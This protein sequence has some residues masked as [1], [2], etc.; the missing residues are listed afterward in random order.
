MRRPR[1]EP[2]PDDRQATLP[3]A[4]AAARRATPT[5]EAIAKTVTDRDPSPPGQLRQARGYAA[6]RP[7][8]RRPGTT[9]RTGGSGDGEA[10]GGR[11]GDPRRRGH[12][13]AHV[14]ALER[15]T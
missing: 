11:A 1:R 4:K 8:P 15:L 5:P 7:A 6:P 14:S 10:R 9:P 3:L 12:G 13:T 2:T